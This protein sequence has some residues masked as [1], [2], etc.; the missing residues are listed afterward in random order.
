MKDEF[1]PPIKER[2]TEQLLK[3]VAAPEKWNPNAVSLAKIELQERNVGAEKVEQTKYLL[4]KKAKYEDL[5]KAKEGYNILDFIFEPGLIF[6][7]VLFSW[8]LKKDGYL[9]KAKQQKYIR[10][11]ILI[12]ILIIVAI[13]W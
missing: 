7:E 3:I 4:N 9:R 1:S 10:I 5:K 8:E 2:T 12:L 6:F 13:N 11:A